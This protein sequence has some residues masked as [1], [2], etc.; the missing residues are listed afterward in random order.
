MKT[1][2]GKRFP[3]AVSRWAAPGA[4]TALL[5]LTR[6]NEVT[7]TE[8]LLALLLS[9]IPWRSYLTWKSSEKSDLPVFSM[10]AFMYWL[11]YV[12]PLFWEPHT[13]SEIYSPAGRELSDA[14]VTMAMLMAVL[15]VGCLWLGMHAR[16]GRLLAPRHLTINLAPSRRHYI[17]AVLAVGCFLNVYDISPYILGEGG[18]QLTNIVTSS[19]PMLAFVIL[20][21]DYLRGESTQ[22]DRIVMAAFVVSRLFNG[23]SSGWLGVSMSLIVVCGVVYLAERRRIPQIAFI[24]VMLFALF[25]QVG[26]EDFRKTYW[27]EASQGVAEGATQGGRLERA[28]FWV[29]RSFE[30][31]GETFADP[32]VETLRDAITPS[33]ARIS[34]LNQTANVID[35]TPSVVPYQYGRLYSYLGV[36]LIPRFLWPDKPSVSEAN[37]FYQVAYGLT[38]EEQLSQVSIAAGTLTEGYI[39]FSWPGAV[40]IMF[41]LGIFFDFYQTTFLSIKSGPLLQAVGVV[42]LPTFL[43]IESQLAQ[44]LGGIIQEV[45]VIL[46]VMLPAIKMTRS[47]RRPRVLQLQH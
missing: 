10:I 46:I 36:T 28:S 6:A 24:L 25:F 29:T 15:G 30:K 34:L 40:G 16:L 33:L 37:Q 12:V 7:V 42:L 9:Y 13:I 2:L 45:V 5:W 39:N 17:R 21:R 19:V 44:Y 38:G 35:L 1:N 8:I 3:K 20:F 22:L 31:W 27:Q 18:R 32:K 4:V 47:F 23:L 43:S 26:K 14:G 41:L 11:F